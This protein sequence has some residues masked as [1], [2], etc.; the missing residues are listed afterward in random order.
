MPITLI[1][2]F[3]LSDHY[4]G[5]MKGVILSINRKIQ[6][7]DISHEIDSQDV[8]QAAYLLKQSYSFFP[9][10]SIHVIVVDPG[11]GSN[12]PII[13]ADAGGY[14]FLAPDNG[15]LKYIFDFYPDAKVFHVNNSKYILKNVSNTFHGRDI[16]SPVAAHLS[17]GVGLDDIG[18]PTN[19]FIVGNIAVPTVGQIEITGEIVYIDRFGNGVTNIDGSLIQQSP[20]KTVIVKG[21]K[22]GTISKTYSEHPKGMLLALIGSSG[23]LEISVNHGNAQNKLNLKTG[24]PVIVELA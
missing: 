2:D 11:V 24:D 7:V 16:F 4:V 8:A 6:I 9:A 22:I 1:T 19:N 12:R 5:V 23:T 10:G 15:A 14:T 18:E 20:G 3:G 13:A 21:K 17:L